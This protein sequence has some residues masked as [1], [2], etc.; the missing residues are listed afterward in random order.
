[1]RWWLLAKSLKWWEE[2]KLNSTARTRQDP[3]TRPLA[4]KLASLDMQE[5]LPK[6]K[7]RKWF[8]KFQK[9]VRAISEGKLNKQNKTIRVLITHISLLITS[10]SLSHRL[11]IGIITPAAAT[12]LVLCW[13]YPTTTY[14]SSHRKSSNY[15]DGESKARDL[16]HTSYL[17]QISVT[18]A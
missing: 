18:Q 12:I 4:T 17:P 3:E 8:D 6:W 7:S 5:R 11:D 1:M 15:P 16:A 10:L 14:C 13:R 2:G 9:V